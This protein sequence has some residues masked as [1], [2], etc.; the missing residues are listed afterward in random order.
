MTNIHHN[1]ASIAYAV[2]NLAMSMTTPGITAGILSRAPGDGAGHITRELAM[3]LDMAI[4]EI[5]MGQIEYHPGALSLEIGEPFERA[6]ST[7]KPIM[8]ILDEAHAAPA[9]SIEAAMQI[10]D[11]RIEGQ[12]CAVLAITTSAGENK[13]AQRMAAG[14]NWDTGR[15]A[16]HRTANENARLVEKFINANGLSS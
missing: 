15:I 1:N 3:A 6:V 8:V 16:M 11:K 4:L 5:R 7:G 14:M 2:V 9:G 13:I 12:P 10:I